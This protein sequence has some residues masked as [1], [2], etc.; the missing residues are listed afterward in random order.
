MHERLITPPYYPDLSE[1]DLWNKLIFLGGPVQGAD[2][3]QMEAYQTIHQLYPNVWVAS[4][5]RLELPQDKYSPKKSYQQDHWETFWL[6]KVRQ[7]DGVALFW[8]AKE[9]NHICRRTFAQTTRD[10]LA[11]FR[12]LKNLNRFQR[13]VVGIEDGFSGASYQRR[14]LRQETP[15]VIIHRSLERACSEAVSLV[16]G[17]RGSYYDSPP[18]QT[19]MF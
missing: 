10:E 17:N 3:W 2:D 11:K 5:R 9:V 8:L 13:L 19:R 6:N 4:P 18:F 12:T 7:L 14:K 15:D 16:K 1:I